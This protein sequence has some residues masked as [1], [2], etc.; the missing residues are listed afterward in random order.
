[1]LAVV[2]LKDRVSRLQGLGIVMA[3]VGIVATGEEGRQG[4]VEL[5]CVE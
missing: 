2:F 1:M 4:E 5:R 3:I